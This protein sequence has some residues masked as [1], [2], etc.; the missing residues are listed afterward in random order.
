MEESCLNCHNGP[1]SKSPKK[2]WK[3][4]DVGGV[5]KIGRRLDQDI[6]ATRTGLRQTIVLMACTAI[7]LLAIGVAVVVGARARRSRT[8]IR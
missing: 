8:S 1:K 7:V 4:G 5:F 3:V 2:D 6:A